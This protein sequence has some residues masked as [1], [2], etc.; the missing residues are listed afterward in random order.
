MN[1]LKKAK[2][3]FNERIQEIFESSLSDNEILSET[4]EKKG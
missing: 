3:Q 1:L 2:H 4:L